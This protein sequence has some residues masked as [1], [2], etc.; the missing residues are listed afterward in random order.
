M[1]ITIRNQIKHSSFRYVSFFI[2]VVLGAGMISIPAL[3]RDESAGASWA[4][5]V[6]GEKVSYKDFAQQV[7]EQS[8]FLAQVRAQYGQYADLLFQAMGWPSDP[9][10]LA[11]EILIKMTLLDQLVSKMGIHI[12]QDYITE[13]INNAQF[14]QEHL[15][16]LL[17]SFLFTQQ[18][19][20]DTEKLKIY[21]SYRGVSIKEFE[22]KI[23]QNLAQLQALQFIA[24]SCY[25]PS[26]DIQQEIIA[27]KM[28]KEFLYLTF[29]HDTF[30][31]AEKKNRVDDQDAR[32]FYDKENVQRRRYWVPEKRD[33]VVWKFS[34]H[35]YITSTNE[36]DI[37]AYYNDNKTTKYVLEN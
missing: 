24:T 6:N 22:R 37:N 2:F 1:I 9:Q 21:L 3:M 30:L 29:S 23:E 15:Q 14:A 4:I 33:G 27:R 10:A 17:P 26:F 16:R 7:A 32:A 31:A 19:T 12:H 20:L 13:S 5:K 36:D 11:F 28:G 34:P 18:G 25:V 35:H 8:E